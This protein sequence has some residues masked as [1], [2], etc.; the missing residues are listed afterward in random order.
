MDDLSMDDRVV[1]TQRPRAPGD[2]WV[3]TCARCQRD[4]QRG[5]T[6]ACDDCVTEAAETAYAAGQRDTR[7][8]RD[9]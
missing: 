4:I 8:E 2:P 6:V 7:A 5:E 9:E 3:C 1:P